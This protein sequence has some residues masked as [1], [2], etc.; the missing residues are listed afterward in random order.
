MTKVT[1]SEGIT[2]FVFS[3]ADIRDKTE[4]ELKDEIKK[5]FAN[6]KES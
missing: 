2:T 4:Q 5:E 6:T 1:K 3:S